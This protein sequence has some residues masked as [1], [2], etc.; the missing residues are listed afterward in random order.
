[1]LFR[2]P[3]QELQM[4]THQRGESIDRERKPLGLELE[5]IEERESK[6]RGEAEERKRRGRGKDRGKTDEREKIGAE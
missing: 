1:M 6:D 5:K 4:K 3:K 2:S